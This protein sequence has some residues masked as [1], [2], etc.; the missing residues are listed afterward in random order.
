MGSQD[1]ISLLGR[2]LHARVPGGRRLCSFLVMEASELHERV[3]YEHVYTSD[4]KFKI[5]RCQRVRLGPLAHIMSELDLGHERSARGPMDHKLLSGNYCIHRIRKTFHDLKLV[6]DVFTVIALEDLEPKKIVEY[7]D[8]TVAIEPSTKED[9][10]TFDTRRWME[11]TGNARCPVVDQSGGPIAKTEL[12]RVIALAAY[13]CHLNSTGK[14]IVFGKEMLHVDTNTF[15]IRFLSKQ[16]DRNVRVQ[17]RPPGF[18]EFKVTRGLAATPVLVGI[19][20]ND[21]PA[22]FQGYVLYTETDLQGQRLEEKRV[23]AVVLG[24]VFESR[25]TSGHVFGPVMRCEDFREKPVHSEPPP[26]P[27]G[28]HARKRKSPEHPEV[29]QEEVKEIRYLPEELKLKNKK[30]KHVRRR[31][32]GWYRRKRKD[33]A[34]RKQT[35]DLGLN[36]S[37][38]QPVVTSENILEHTGLRTTTSTAVNNR[39]ECPEPSADHGDAAFSDNPDSDVDLR[40]ALETI[41]RDEHNGGVEE[42]HQHQFTPSEMEKIAAILKEIEGDENRESGSGSGKPTK[43][44]GRSDLDGGHPDTALFDGSGDSSGLCPTLAKTEEGFVSLDTAD[45]VN[46]YLSESG[47]DVERACFSDIYTDEN[48]SDAAPQEEAVTDRPGDSIEVEPLPVPSIVVVDSTPD[49]NTCIDITLEDLETTVTVTTRQNVIVSC[50]PTGEKPVVEH[51][52]QLRTPRLIPFSSGR[53]NFQTQYTLSDIGRAMEKDVSTTTRLMANLLKAFRSAAYFYP[54]RESRRAWLERVL[55]DVNFEEAVRTSVALPTIPISTKSAVMDFCLG[56]IG[57]GPFETRLLDTCIKRKRSRFKGRHRPGGVRENHLQYDRYFAALCERLRPLDSPDGDCEI[58]VEFVRMFT[59]EPN[60]GVAGAIS[61]FHDNKSLVSRDE[62]VE[63]LV[64]AG[65][66]LNRY[67]TE[68]GA[69]ASNTTYP[70]YVFGSNYVWIQ[71]DAVYT[72]R[73]MSRRPPA[74]DGEAHTAAFVKNLLSTTGMVF[75]SNLEASS[76]AAVNRDGPVLVSLSQNGISIRFSFVM[77]NSR[78]YTANVFYL[79]GGNTCATDFRYKRRY[80]CNACQCENR[81]SH[82]RLCVSVAALDGLGV[83]VTPT[84]GGVYGFVLDVVRAFRQTKADDDD[85]FLI[86]QFTG[87]ALINYM[88]DSNAV[89]GMVK[90][91]NNDSSA[92]TC[93]IHRWLRGH[94]DDNHWLSTEQSVAQLLLQSPQLLVVYRPL[95]SESATAANGPGIFLHYKTFDDVVEKYVLLSS[96]TL[97]DGFAGKSKTI[98]Y[99]GCDN[100]WVFDVSRRTDGGENTLES[101]GKPVAMPMGDA[102]QRR[103]E[104]SWLNA[105]GVN[106]E[107][108]T[109]ASRRG[110]AGNETSFFSLRKDVSDLFQRVFSAPSRLCV[111]VRVL[112]ELGFNVTAVNVSKPTRLFTHTDRDTNSQCTVICSSPMVV[113]CDEKIDPPDDSLQI[114]EHRQKS[115]GGAIM[116]SHNKDTV[117]SFRKDTIDLDYVWSGVHAVRISF[118]DVVLENVNFVFFTAADGC[119][120][121]ERLTHEGLA[122][123]NRHNFE[124]SW[125]LLPPPVVHTLHGMMLQR[126]RRTK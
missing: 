83:D 39:S 78:F 76:V 117:Q 36:D 42:E 29:A 112:S 25:N 73:E 60:T 84:K 119:D 108:D 77:P 92:F 68:S 33:D 102:H 11:F 44:A 55:F 97:R 120:A 96:E 57:V 3:A 40:L 59:I 75:V 69:A 27:A 48:V 52:S 87:L 111:H 89:G 31:K 47:L 105:D 98:A 82:W 56:H 4:V 66:H 58:R 114:M 121:L 103:V 99:K 2:R 90:G 54:T 88:N 91:A 16:L 63:T 41:V 80:L 28:R 12:R 45:M 24:P 46:E 18:S 101:T 104:P 21:H 20:N 81:L 61:L 6:D 86:N 14:K 100:Y 124:S 5:N 79:S 30:R 113:T 17:P 49:T 95:V 64:S 116:K 110:A 67:M 115:E 74:I 53:L 37:S 23:F 106:E 123:M 19:L 70:V 85:H 109:V 38:G 122:R 26:P 15:Y 118:N 43:Y 72:L 7:L 10:S 9:D 1:R 51:E 107:V 34:A 125:Q 13:S 93:E 94:T 22:G 71:S 8:T 35:T 65:G 62:C 32:T 126:A 50:T